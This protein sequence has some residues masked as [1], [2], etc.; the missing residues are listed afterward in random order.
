MSGKKKLDFDVEAGFVPHTLC[1]VYFPAF[2][3]SLRPLAGKTRLF[4]QTW[5]QNP[6]IFLSRQA[7]VALIK[8]FIWAF[9]EFFRAHVR[10]WLIE[11]GGTVV[12]NAH[13]DVATVAVDVSVVKHEAFHDAGRAIVVDAFLKR[14]Y[15][16][17]YERCEGNFKNFDGFV[18][19]IY[20]PERQL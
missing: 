12:G 5:V 20:K 19:K 4:V 3:G 1:D 14:G 7:D 17:V 9:K 13:I 18:A 2:Y 10:L 6:A 11:K 8:P 15:K 16:V